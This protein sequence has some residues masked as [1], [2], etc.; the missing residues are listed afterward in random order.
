[1]NEV[2]GWIM[3][4]ELFFTIIYNDV[5]I[6]FS[7]DVTEIWM[8]ARGIMVLHTSH[9]KTTTLPQ[10]LMSLNCSLRILFR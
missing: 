4:F 1:M 9:L 5:I 8:A 6:S 10:A 3:L 2:S 7:L